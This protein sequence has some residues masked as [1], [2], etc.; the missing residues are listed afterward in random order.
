MIGY[1]KASEIIRKCK[2]TAQVACTVRPGA[3][4]RDWNFVRWGGRDGL[5][6]FRGVGAYPRGAGN[7]CSKNSSDHNSLLFG[8]HMPTESQ[9]APQADLRSVITADC[10]WSRTTVSTVTCSLSQAVAPSHC[11]GSR[12]RKSAYNVINCY[13]LRY[14]SLNASSNSR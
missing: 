5:T 3:F 2:S 1:A 11:C 6:L 13:S 9:L 4:L 10:R 14:G 8:A 7:P 12:A